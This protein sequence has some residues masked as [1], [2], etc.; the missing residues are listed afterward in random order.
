[1]Y[2]KRS[3]LNQFSKF[4]FRKSS[5]SKL[6]IWQTRAIL[7]SLKNYVFKNNLQIISQIL[8]NNNIFLKFSFK[9]GK[10]ICWDN[11]N[12]ASIFLIHSYISLNNMS[13]LPALTWPFCEKRGDLIFNQKSKKK[14]T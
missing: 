2:K 8:Y 5:D 11:I 6:S 1:M 9:F 4:F 7:K 12:K 13:L 10:H 14:D 3:K